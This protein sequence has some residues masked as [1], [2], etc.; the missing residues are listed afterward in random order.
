M[1]V[2]GAQRVRVVEVDLVLAEVALALGVLDDHPRRD[3]AV[4]DAADQ[5]LHAGGAEQRVVD[6]VEVRRVQI[7]IALVPRL[8][9]GVLED[10]E[11]ELGARVGAPAALG[12]ARELPAQDLAR[13]GDHVRAV[14]PG[15]VGQAH[16]RALLPGHGA[17]RV[18]V[19]LEQHVAVAALPRGHR[20]ALDRAHVDVDRQQVVAALRPVLGHLVE[21]VRRRQAL[22][23]QAPLHVGHRQQDR[24]DCA[25]GD[26]LGQF[27]ECHVVKVLESDL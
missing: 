21:E 20:V 22:A 19:W 26:R 3:H 24:V 17:Q 18:E 9:V 23:L 2:G 25:P 6:V 1:L 27:V 4:A 13:G 7:A 14:E 5:R 8:L 15:D 12:Q 10:Q 11:L 16:H